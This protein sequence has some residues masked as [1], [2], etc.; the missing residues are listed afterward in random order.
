MKLTKKQKYIKE[1]YFKVGD[2]KDPLY[3]RPITDNFMRLA[4]HSLMVII[5][6][7]IKILEQENWDG[8][9]WVKTT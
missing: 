4:P 8:L 3:Y 7:I 5:D 2:D 1:K 9:N 6:L